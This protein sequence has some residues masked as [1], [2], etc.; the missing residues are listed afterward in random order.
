MIYV[1]SELFQ[2]EDTFFSFPL[3]RKA[4]TN[5][6]SAF[7]NNSRRVESSESVFKLDKKCQHVLYEDHLLQKNTINK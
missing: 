3:L 2:V 4:N 1:W 5:I 7:P 6:S